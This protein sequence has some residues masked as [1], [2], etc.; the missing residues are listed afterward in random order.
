MTINFKK[1]NPDA[2]APLRAT[3]SSAGADFYAF[4]REDVVVNAGQRLLIPTGIAV[5]IPVG[6]GG[7]VFPRS[8]LSSK[9]GITLA[10]CVG[11]IDADYRGEVGVALI[12]HSDTAYT[13]SNGDRIAQLVIARVEM[14]EFIETDELPESQ[15]G[16]GGF[17]SSGV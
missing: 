4:L 1:L 2:K 7:F 11:V 15:R 16:E 10:N 17:G 5:E 9:H 8:S 14:I 6:Y 13:V 12:N 3:Q